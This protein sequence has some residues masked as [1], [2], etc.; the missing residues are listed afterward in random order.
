MDG[1][2]G[3][4]LLG[5]EH[6]RHDGTPLIEPAMRAGKVVEPRPTLEQSRE[7]LAG[8]LATLPGHLKHLE[9]GPE[10]P[11][12]VSSDLRALA[13]TVDAQVR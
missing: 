1:T 11:V 10:Y 12:T 4:D 3:G 6:E 8:E 2:I 5:L 13:E 7:R 9:A